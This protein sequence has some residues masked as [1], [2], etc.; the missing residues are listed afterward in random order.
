MHIVKAYS[1]MAA[2]C[3]QGETWLISSTQVNSF[4]AL[5][6]D[7]FPM[8][9]ILRKTASHKVTKVYN[10]Q[11]QCMQYY[12]ALPIRVISINWES[13]LMYAVLCKW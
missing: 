10:I 3:T 13:G 2:V 5:S 1:C 9:E 6:P 11:V 12:S 7:F 8:I 4:F